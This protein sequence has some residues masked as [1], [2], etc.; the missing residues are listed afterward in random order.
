MNITLFNMTKTVVAHLSAD[1]DALAAIWLVR[2]F[3]PDFAEANLAFI[4]QGTT[5]KDK[6]VDSD[7]NVIHVDTGLGKFDHH[8]NNEDT[9]AAK[10]VFQYLR[11]NDMIRD[12]FDEP[13]ERMTDVINDIDHFRESSWPNPDS[14]IYEFSIVSI[15]EGMK[16]RLQDDYYLA[17]MAESIFDGILQTFSNKI[18]A[19]KEIEKGMIF[20]SYWGKTLALN[21]ESDEAGQLA[22]K[23]GYDMVIR[24]S[25]RRNHLKIKLSPSSKKTLKKLDKLVREADKKAYWFYHASGHMLISGSSKTPDITPSNLTLNEVVEIIKSIKK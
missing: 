12:R 7:P 15:I 17:V 13:L 1:V 21:S 11:D 2:K 14:D 6:P 19:E 5:F 3:M 9:C 16:I 24:K 20:K 8:Q 25:P 23:K 22:Q 10:K 18:Q 4:A